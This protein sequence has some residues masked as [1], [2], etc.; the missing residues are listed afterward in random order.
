MSQNLNEKLTKC[1]IDMF[2]FLEFSGGEIVNE[3]VAVEKLEQLN[4]EIQI[5]D[6]YS[7]EL[8]GKEII[9]LSDNYPENR[10]DF[11]RKMPESLGIAN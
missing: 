6:G 11:I 4:S 8:L 5:L 2:I 3:D 9:K 1:L 10:I 7:K